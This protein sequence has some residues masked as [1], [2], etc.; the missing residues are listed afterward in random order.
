M[1]TDVYHSA[2]TSMACLHEHELSDHRLFF[3]TFGAVND[4]AADSLDVFVFPELIRHLDNNKSCVSGST[5]TALLLLSQASL[6]HT[7]IAVLF[8]LCN[9]WVT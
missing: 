5:I 3:V 4:S 7:H 6:G 8:G 2:R 9:D 1:T